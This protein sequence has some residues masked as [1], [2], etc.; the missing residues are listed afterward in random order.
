MKAQRR[1]LQHVDACILADGLARTPIDEFVVWNGAPFTVIPG[2][3][4]ASILPLVDV[5]GVAVPLRRLVLQAAR[6]DGALGFPPDAVR[7][8]LPTGWTLVDTGEVRELR[9][10]GRPWLVRETVDA[11][12]LR[13]R[14]LVDGYELTIASVADGEAVP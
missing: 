6:I 8:A 4:N 12:T 13:V 3:V 10:D 7:A 2:S 9:K 5:P 14:N 1:E 11:A